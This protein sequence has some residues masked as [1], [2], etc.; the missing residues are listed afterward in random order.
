M[1]LTLRPYKPPSTSWAFLSI[2]VPIMTIVFLFDQVTKYWA[3]STLCPFNSFPAQGSF[4][5]VCTYNTGSAFGMF[6]DQTIPLIFASFAGIGLLLWIYKTHLIRGPWLHLSMGLQLGGAVGNLTDRLRFG[7]VT[8]FIQLAFWPVFNLA[9]ASIVVGVILLVAVFLLPSRF[10]VT[11]R[12]AIRS[13]GMLNDSISTEENTKT[14]T[15]PI[16]AVTIEAP[17]SDDRES[18]HSDPNGN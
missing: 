11:D 8:D 3:E 13:D 2:V 1:P 6:Q 18:K 7:Q 17:T 4:K 10:G 12:S 15:E 14:T 9:D 16:S 5:F